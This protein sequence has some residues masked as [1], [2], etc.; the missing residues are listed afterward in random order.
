MI[1]IAGL[2]LN[3]QDVNESIQAFMLRNNIL[4]DCLKGIGSFIYFFLGMLVDFLDKVFTELTNVDLSKIINIGDL[5]VALDQ[6]SWWLLL[7]SIMALCIIKMFSAGHDYVFLRNALIIIVSLT[8]FTQ[9]VD[10]M[11]QIKTEGV[12]IIDHSLGKSKKI[13]MSEKVFRDN[14][15]DILASIKAERLKRINKKVDISLIDPTEQMSKHDLQGKYI[16]DDAGNKTVKDLKDGIM[17]IGDERWYRYYVNYVSI[18]LTLVILAFFYVIG[19]FKVCYISWDLFI[20]KLLGSATMAVSVSNLKKLQVVFTYVA[21]SIATFLI[22][23]GMMILF[24]NV[25]S[26]VLTADLIW[27]SKLILM[28][29]FGW[30]CI[31]GSGFVTKGLGMDDGTMFLMKSLFVGSRLSRM[32]KKGVQTAMNLGKGALDLAEKAGNAA[33][34]GASNMAHD[35]MGKSNSRK[36]Q[37]GMDRFAESMSDRFQQPKLEGGMY[38]ND[39]MLENHEEMPIDRSDPNN[40]YPD[41]GRVIGDS[42]RVVGDGQSNLYRNRLMQSTEPT[43]EKS[44]EKDAEEEPIKNIG[45]VDYSNTK[46]YSQYKKDFANGITSPYIDKNAVAKEM[47]NPQPMEKPKYIGAVDYSKVKPY[48][49]Y[50]RDFANGDTSIERKSPYTDSNKQLPDWYNDEA[51]SQREYERT[52]KEW[53]ER[54]G[55][56]SEFD[57]AELQRDLA[58]LDTESFDK[59]LERKMAFLRGEI[60]DP[61]DDDEM[62]SQVTSDFENESKGE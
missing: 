11:Q 49:Q 28:F 29:V 2:G 35:M 34:N 32:G 12:T 1:F 61:Y 4:N 44:V 27:L 51:A 33:Y 59:E 42:E 14:S 22:T 43:D 9:Y 17:E 23:Y 36:M 45:K 38:A 40:L 54:M 21:K 48:A 7:L 16:Y 6:L 24:S 39:R 31:I 52:Q 62:L 5:D 50:K 15:Y 30:L 46:P 60:S 18:N 20:T 25:V 8:V 10:F 41:N 53:Q 58:E 47:K 37:E 3:I 26:S 19:A 57:E 56:S 13:S 55:G